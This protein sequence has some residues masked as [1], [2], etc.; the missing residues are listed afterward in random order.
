MARGRRGQQ[1]RGRRPARARALRR[2][3]GVQRDQALPEGRRRRQLHPVDRHA[4]RRRSQR[5]HELGRDR[6]PA[7]GP[8][9]Q[10]GVHRQG[11]L[12]PAR[13]GRRRHLRPQG[14]RQG[15]RRR[16]RGVA[17]QSRRRPAPVRQAEQDPVPRLALRRSHHDRRHQHDRQGAARRA[18]SLLQGLVSPRPDGGD[19]RR[20]D[21]SRAGEGRDREAVR[22]SQEPGERAPAHPR[23]GAQGRRHARL[24]RHRPRAHGH[25]DLD[26]QPRAEAAAR[27]RARRS[28]AARRPGLRGD[29][30]RAVRAAPPQ[31]RRAVH[32]G[33]GVDGPARADP[34]DGRLPGLRAGQGR[35]RRGRAARAAD[36]DR[37]RRPPR[38]HAERARARE[39]QHRASLRGRGDDRGDRAEQRLRRGAGAALHGPRAGDRSVGRARA[40]EEVP[41][42]DHRR[43]AQ[44]AR[45]ELRRRVEPHDPDLGAGRQAARHAGPRAEDRRRG[46]EERHRGVGRQAGRDDADRRRAGAGQDR[47]REEARQDRRHRVEAVQRRARDR[48]ADRL[49]GRQR[50]ARGPVDRRRGDGQR[51]GLPRRAVRERGRVG[52]RARQPRRRRARE[53]ARREIGAGDGWDRRDHR[54]GERARLGEGHRDDVPARVSA[55]DGAAQGRRRGQ[56]VEDGRVAAARERGAQPGVPVP[57]ARRRHA[58]QQQR[59]PDVPGSVGDR[60]VRCRQGAR[61]LQ[62]SVRRRVG[63]HVRDRRRGRPRQAAPA[64]RDLPREPA[65]EEAHG[66]RK[67]FED[68]QGARRREEG[69]ARRRGAE[70]DRAARLPRRRDVDARQGSRHAHPR[71]GAERPAAQGPPRGSRRR[72][73][74][75]GIGEHHAVAAPGALVRRGVHLRSGPRRRADRGGQRPDREAAKG[76]RGS[77][78]ARQ[79]EASR[80]CASARPSSARTATG[81]AG[82]RTRIATATIRRWCSIRRA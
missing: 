72:L 52:E 10:A 82:W 34:R 51:Q 45:G 41:A 68:P 50:R 13:L 59:A 73:Q 38:L 23:R 5:A 7:R 75:A 48:Q 19:H 26:G 32:R 80:S 9:G 55:H 49:R 66:C 78:R 67:G 35:P 71:R 58:L 22:R 11:L 56:G 31:A 17:R 30:E 24:D 74:L 69:V 2:A 12:D 36:R 62:G 39:D 25:D 37:A 64:R 28:P 81:R 60:R 20:R 47:E 61:V 4:V 42:D 16:G 3:H 15:A 29:H 1:P 21:R 40:G 14:G 79:G 6:L 53:G 8:V 33:G 70:G 46:R 63:L 43:R 57:E 18:L 77:G 65:D 54:A 44:Q 76:G 27:E